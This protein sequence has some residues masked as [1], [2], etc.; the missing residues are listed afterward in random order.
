MSI[1]PYRGGSRPEPIYVIETIIDNAARELGIEPAE[2]RRRNTIP[3]EAMPFTTVLQQTYDSGDFVKNLDDC[4]A[5]ADHGEL[6]S[7]MSAE[8]GDSEDVLNEF[9]RAGIQVDDLAK[10]LQDDGAK[11]FVKSWNELLAIIDSRSHA[12]RQAA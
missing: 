2:L 12:L 5:L 9:A 6:G 7:I 3:A 4:L 11:A 10:Q 8:G 1:A